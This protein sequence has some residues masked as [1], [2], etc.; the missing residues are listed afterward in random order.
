MLSLIYYYFFLQAARPTPFLRLRCVFRTNECSNPPTPHPHPHPKSCSSPPS[1]PVQ[2]KRGGGATTEGVP[3]GQG[4]ERE[5]EKERGR[6][7]GAGGIIIIQTG[8]E[9]QT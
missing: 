2:C 6:G 1:P 3:G 7:G 9:E 8:E 4:G 5:R